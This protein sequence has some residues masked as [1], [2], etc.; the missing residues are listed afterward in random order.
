VR[1]AQTMADDI[2]KNITAM[3]DKSVAAGIKF[4]V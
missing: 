2:F 3:S 4:A 1:D